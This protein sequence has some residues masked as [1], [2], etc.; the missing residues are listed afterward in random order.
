[1]YSSE[2]TLAYVAYPEAVSQLPVAPLWSVL[3]FLMLCSLAVD[4]QFLMVESIIVALTDEFSH[5]LRKR[6][7]WVI[8]TLCVIM[9]LLGL[10]LVTPV[11]GFRESVCREYVLLNLQSINSLNLTM[12]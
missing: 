11:S 12:L 8:V 4:S 5:H 1:M 6:R 3:F 9:F 10:P 7:L 2:F